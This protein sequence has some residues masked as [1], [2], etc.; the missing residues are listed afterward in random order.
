M[1][2]AVD[3]RGLKSLDADK[4][5]GFPPGT[6]KLARHTGTLYGQEPPPFLKIGRSV[7]YLKEDLDTW[8]NQF[9]KYSNVAEAQQSSASVAV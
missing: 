2:H 3:V 4:Y 7:L 5:Q 1:Q 8:L 6:H 9:K